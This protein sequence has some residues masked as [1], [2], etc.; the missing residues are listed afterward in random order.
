MSEFENFRVLNRLAKWRKF[1][2]SWQLGT[3]S[4]GN[5]TYRAVADHREATIMLRAEVSALS[6]ILANKGVFTRDEYMRAL[7]DE[8]NRLS[9]EYEDKFRGWKATDA[10]M[11]MNLPAAS[12]TMRRMGFPL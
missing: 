8:A 11:E 5:G 9:A 12:E 6:T 7:L 1:F 10:G 3:T 4:E 2:A